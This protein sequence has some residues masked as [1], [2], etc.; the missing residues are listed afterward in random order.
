MEGSTKNTLFFV[1]LGMSSVIGWGAVVASSDFFIQQYPDYK[2]AFLMVLPV[3]T[4]QFLMSFFMLPLQKALTRKQIFVYSSY[5][6]IFI[7]LA[8]PMVGWFIPGLIGFSV[9][10]VLSLA[11]GANITI[12]LI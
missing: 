10:I 1:L 5:L 6:Q 4:T 12:G 2:I 11:S 3:V 9:I 8:L 7:L